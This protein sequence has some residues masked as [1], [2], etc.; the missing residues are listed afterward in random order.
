MQQHS[1]I[2]GLVIRETDFSDQDRYITVL[3]NSGAKIE[4]ICRGIRRKGSRLSNA[5]RLFCYAEMQL[6]E[7]RGRFSLHDASLVT[8][9]WGVTQDIERYALAC[10]FAELSSTLCQEDSLCAA[11]TTLT[12]YALRAL[13]KGKQPLPLIKAAYELRILAESGYLPQLR[14]CGACQSVLLAPIF[15]S[16]REGTAV[17]ARC[18]GRIG[19]DWTGLEQGTFAAMH[20]VAFCALEKVFAFTLGET[21]LQQLSAVCEKYAIY[22]VDKPFESLK[23]YHSLFTPLVK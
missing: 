7:S 10:Y 13:E 12:L 6:Y 20:H 23:F 18:A 21:S 1:N 9:F 14:V 3:T 15:F 8:S 11:I 22:H 17:C 4:V 16:I 19:G 2:H 5:V